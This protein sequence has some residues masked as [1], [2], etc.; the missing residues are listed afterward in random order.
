VTEAARAWLDYAPGELALGRVMLL[1]TPTN[2]ASIRVADPDVSGRGQAPRWTPI[3]ACTKWV[4]HPHESS[5]APHYSSAGPPPGVSREPR[6]TATLGFEQPSAARI[7][8]PAAARSTT[9]SAAATSAALVQRVH[10][11]H[12]HEPDLRP[13]HEHL[14]RVLDQRS[15]PALGRAPL[16]HDPPQLVQVLR[17]GCRPA[18]ASR[19]TGRPRRVPRGGPQS[20]WIAPPAA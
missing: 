13:Q 3:P 10:D 16:G 15:P 7:H 11:S 5:G 1:V 20:G 8:F 19:R 17:P 2:T 6:T 4:R 18:C 9:K 12:G 14:R